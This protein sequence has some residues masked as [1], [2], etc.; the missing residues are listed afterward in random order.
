MPVFGRHL[1]GQRAEQVESADHPAAESER[2]PVHRPEALLEHC[3]AES[4]PAVAEVVDVAHAHRRA[5]VEALDAGTE[6]RA[7][8]HDLDEAALL[9]RRRD[10]RQ[11]ACRAVGQHDAR[12]RRVEQIAAGVDERLQQIYHV[13]VGHQRVREGDERSGQ[14]SFSCFARHF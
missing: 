10:D 4:G 9:A 7:Q 8:L 2:N 11:L 6:A 5:R 13:V 3:L 12:G 1:A 14:L